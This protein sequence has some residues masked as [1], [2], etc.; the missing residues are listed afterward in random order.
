MGLDIY[1]NVQK[2]ENYID[3]RD[4]QEFKNFETKY[5]NAIRKNSNLANLRR[6]IYKDKMDWQLFYKSRVHKNMKKVEEEYRELKFK[7]YDRIHQWLNTDYRLYDLFNEVFEKNHIN[8]EYTSTMR[9]DSFSLSLE[10]LIEVYNRYKD[11]EL[12]K[13]DEQNLKMIEEVIAKYTPAHWIKF[14]WWI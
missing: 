12:E 8:D 3:E 13:V 1:L 9:E 4:F 7:T 2:K 14:S 5:I 6:K 11:L 10:D